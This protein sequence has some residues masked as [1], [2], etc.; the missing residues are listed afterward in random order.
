MRHKLPLELVVGRRTRPHDLFGSQEVESYLAHLE[1]AVRRQLGGA[2]RRGPLRDLRLRAA[3]RSPPRARLLGRRRGGVAASARPPDPALRPPRHLRRRSCSPAQAFVAHAT[4]QAARAPRDARDR[5]DPR[6]DPA[7]AARRAA[8]AATSSSR[9]TRPG[10]SEPDGAR[11]IGVA[12]DVMLIH[13]GAQS[14]LYAALAWT[15]VDLLL[16][17]D[18]AAPRSQPATT[19]CSSAA[20]T[21]RS[22]GAALAHAAPRD[23][24]ARARARVRDASALAPG[25]MIATMLSATNTSA[26]PGLERFDP[27]H[28]EG[29]RLAKAVAAAGAR[30]GQHLR[31]RPPRLPGAALLDQRDPHRR[32]PAARA[33]RARRRASRAP[34]RG[35]ARSAPSRARRVPARSST[36]RAEPSLGRPPPGSVRDPRARACARI[37]SSTCWSKPSP[38]PAAARRA[39]FGARARRRARCERLRDLRLE[40]RALLELLLHVRVALGRRQRLRSGAGSSSF[41]HDVELHAAFLD[42]VD[43]VLAAGVDAAAGLREVGEARGGRRRRR[44]Q[45]GLVP[46]PRAR[47]ARPRCPTRSPSRPARGS[48]V[49]SSASCGAVTASMPPSWRIAT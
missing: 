16:R 46:C 11:A 1:E 37:A 39:S 38:L 6:R 42:R 48:G 14:N 19:R 12:R 4:R 22:A 33:L 23:A 29:R 35:G 15:L 8:R 20:P 17:P 3:P 41:L 25:V 2:R 13:M 18:A 27:D 30:A 45:R 34:R 26:A 49:A 28:Y 43:Q 9:S 47:P 10:P 32:A 21:S 7:R 44:R 31:P 5:G 24:A 36:A 40:L